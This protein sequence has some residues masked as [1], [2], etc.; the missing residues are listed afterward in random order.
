MR[1]MQQE[2]KNWN[3]EKARAK[4]IGNKKLQAQLKK[5]EKMM[6]Q[7]QSKMLKGQMVS[8]FAT[9]GIFYIM[10]YGLNFIF[11]ANTVAYL[12]FSIPFVLDIPALPLSFFYWYLICSFLASSI[13]SRILGVGVGLGGLQPNIEK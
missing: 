13:I 12:P 3:E 6:M 2:F 11:G 7:K 1:E 5:K 4:K 9:I 10:Y 8:M